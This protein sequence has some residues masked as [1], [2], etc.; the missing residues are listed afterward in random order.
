MKKNAF[1]HLCA[2]SVTAISFLLAVPSNSE[3]A[4]VC[5]AP[6]AVCEWRKRIVGIKTPNMIASGILIKGNQIVT[7]RHVVEDHQSILVKN[8]VGSVEKAEVIPHDIPVDLAIVTSR[9]NQIGLDVSELLAKTQSQTLYVVAFDQGRNAARVYKHS[10]FALY[11][12]LEEH[13]ISRIHSNSKALPGNSGGAVVNQHGMLVGVLAS[14]DH[15]ISEIIPAVNIDKVLGSMG[16]LHKEAFFEIGGFIRRCADAL[17]ASASILKDPPNP[18]I[19][20]IERN[21]LKSQNKQLLDQAGQTFG[22]WWMF[23]NSEKFLRKS[24]EFDPRSP[25][26]L[27]SLA[28]NYHLSRKPEQ[29]IDVLKRYLDL[30]PSNQ[31]ALRLSI[32]NAGIVR[33][34]AF[35][36]KALDLMEKH[37][38]SALPLAN[39]YIENAFSD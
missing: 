19:S 9:F 31:Q 29:A 34:R 16:A 30:D 5:E 37:N 11:P 8:F 12:K 6:S 26:T 39:S 24:E 7:N 17:H 18:I 2:Q 4:V 14:G 15:R 3:S 32:Q 10:N 23:E 27:M 25:N 21:C 13:P 20:K 33:D 38:P 28:V 22:R 1:L 35:A 36:D